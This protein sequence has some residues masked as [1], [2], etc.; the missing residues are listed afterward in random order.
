M[1]NSVISHEELAEAWPALTMEERLE[2]F[3]LLNRVDAE[4]LFL[5]LE[6]YQQAELL[7][8]FVAPERRAWLRL[9]PPDDAADLVQ[10]VDAGQRSM[11][12][13]LLDE[14]TRREVSALLAYAEDA[15][16]GLMNPRF[17]RLRPDMSVDE[18]ILYLRRQTRERVESIYYAYVLDAGQKLLGVVSLRQLMSAPPGKVV[19]EVMRV[20]LVTVPE[21]MDQ[22]QVSH[23]F[24]EHDLMVLPVVDGEGRMKGIVTV[25][26]IVDVVQEEA[27]EDMHKIGG[28]QALDVP[29]PEISLF[30]L[31]KKRAPWLAALLVG[32]TITAS[33]MGFYEHQLERAAIL[34]LFLPLIISS[35]GNS[36][37]QASTL[38]IR[39]M[40]LGE[41]ALGNWW[42]I[43]RR[44]VLVG[45][46][47]GAILGAIGLLRVLLWG[48]FG[49]HGEHYVLVGTTV[50]LAL[51]GV[52][53]WG[54]ITGSMLPFL[55]RRLGF[56]PASASAPFVA[57]MVD[58]TGILIYF[59]V[60]S[61]VLRGTLL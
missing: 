51:I 31:V 35:G 15:A 47:L 4:E 13:D 50:S 10:Q 16:G 1:T 39:S 53:L 11:L 22:E 45:L 30:E 29:Y 6:S 43:L 34:M 19:R 52:V 33:A 17:A 37:S 46:S 61:A 57:T 59:E 12:L 55:L 32:E 41:V 27:T 58:V 40:A 14:Q 2:G 28:M 54:S 23:V 18:A 49:H 5:R 9:L 36:G 56:D 21:D 20:G 25:D 3:A 42:R 7:L 38:V 60:A 26:D 24:A 8:A 48:A 44:E